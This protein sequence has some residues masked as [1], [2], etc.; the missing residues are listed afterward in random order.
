LPPLGAAGVAQQEKEDHERK[1]GQH[2]G[3]RVCARDVARL[4]L[5]EDLERPG[6]R[7][8]TQIAGDHHR[9]AEFAERVG[10]RQQSPGE[11]TAAKRG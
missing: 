9:R 2:G 3:D 10:E 8:Q 5:R 7:A 6:L 1:Q 11:K 4:E